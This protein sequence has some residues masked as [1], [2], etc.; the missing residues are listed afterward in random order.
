LAGQ[1]GQGND[2]TSSSGSDEAAD[3]NT[4]NLNAMQFQATF[5]P[6][7][8]M[9]NFAGQPAMPQMPMANP[10]MGGMNPYMMNPMMPGSM[11]PYMM[12]PMM[13][14]GMNPYMMNPMMM[15]MGGMMPPII[16]QM[17]ATDSGRR[18]GLFAR[19][20]AAREESQNRTQQ[21]SGSLASLFTQ[22]GMSQQAQMPAKAAYPYGYFGVTASPY[23]SGNFG[24]Y[25]D[26]STQTV[27]YPGM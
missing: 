9:P 13:M 27:R 24:G 5:I 4:P 18:R 17:P 21:A 25:N 2:S 19:L 1:Q 26:M 12:N 20:R 14:G 11:N 7:S 6:A 16:I 22:P 15:G 3:P 10:M 23:Q 8:Q